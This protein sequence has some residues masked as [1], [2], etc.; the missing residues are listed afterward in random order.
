MQKVKLYDTTLRDG[1][2]GEGISF[3]VA[4]KI[5][6]AEKLDELGVHYIEG[7]WPGSNPKDIEFFESIKK[8]KFK[9]TKISAFGST[10]RKNI[11]ASE[12]NNIKKLLEA[13][14]PVITIFGKSWILHVKEVLHVNP[15]ENLNMIS[16]SI[17]YLKSKKKEVFYDA[18]HF[19]DGFKDDPE[20]ALKTLKSA[21][22]AGADCIILCDTNGGT[23]SMEI[24]EIIEQV[25][26]QIKTPLGIHVH[27]DNG[28]AVANSITAVETGIAQIQG[29]INGY[30]ERCGNANLC[31]I[32]P[33]IKLKLSVSCISDK[34]LATLVD[35]SKFVDELANLRHSH[36]LPYVGDSAFAHKGGMHVDAVKKN[37]RSFEHIDPVYYPDT[38][39]MHCNIITRK[40]DSG[41]VTIIGG[42]EYD[43]EPGDLLCY[44]VSEIK[45]KVTLTKGNTNRILWVFG[46]CLPRDKAEDVFQ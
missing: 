3:S 13:D 33:N 5:R 45:H 4:D 21:E 10:R 31:T 18:E 37:S 46:F 6:I 35:V 22:K 25:K 23:L 17:E 9:N 1:T 24:K 34:Q 16:D 2:Q 38:V 42:V 41:G 11:K 40:A 20:Y 36:K 43:I 29:T 39:T 28:L 27:N 15:D 44:P 30:G 32:I 19:F 8:I 14:T 12:D 7:G 26:K